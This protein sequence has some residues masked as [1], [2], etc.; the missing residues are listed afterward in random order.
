[1]K[2]TLYDRF[3][4]WLFPLD[5]TGFRPYIMWVTEIDER[6]RKLHRENKV[7]KGIKI[8]N[9]FYGPKPHSLEY[10]Y[11]ATLKESISF[12]IWFFC[13]WNFGITLLG[14]EIKRWYA[15][16]RIFGFTFERLWYQ[17]LKFLSI[18]NCRCVTIP[19]DISITEVK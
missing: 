15:G 17:D 12:G 7:K 11:H 3:L 8:R 2:T 14:S 18:I 9:G 16:F 4:E 5:G 1:M 6:V 10:Q 19:K 13:T